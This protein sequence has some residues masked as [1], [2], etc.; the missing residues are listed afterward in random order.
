MTDT[1]IKT[2]KPEPEN[3][4]TRKKLAKQYERVHNILF[5]I[6]IVFTL[7]VLMVFIFTG[8]NGGYSNQ[9]A[10]LIRSWSNNYWLQVSIYITITT[11]IYFLL[12]TPFSFYGG[13]LLEHKYQLSNESF[14]MWIKDR[15]KSY[16]LN[17]IFMLLLGLV[18]YVFLVYA[19]HSWWLW[20]GSMWFLFGIILSNIF[21][22]IIIPLFYKLKP[23]ENEDLKNKLIFLSE[24]VKAKISGVYEIILS[25]KTK[26]ANAALTGLGNTKRI[27]L[28]DTLLD[29][30]SNEEIEV[31]LAHEL[32]HFYYKH[33]WKLIFFGAFITF[34]GLYLISL[35][36][37]DVVM[38]LGYNG[39]ADIA[40]F[41]VF[42]LCMFLFSIFTSPLNSTYSRYLEN[43]ADLFAL[44]QTNLPKDFITAMTKL[45]DQ[46]LADDQPNPII[47]F[48]LHDHPSIS[49][50]IKLAERFMNTHKAS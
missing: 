1:T 5:L 41:P 40:G 38:N 48:L 27:I 16:I 39:I 24:K 29:N 4:E 23:L 32:G 37:N 45:A 8:G 15:F 17:V 18:L 49:R 42:L 13:Y 3:P 12:L 47:E 22:I 30:F 11:T 7:M 6:D 14:W 26:K 50:R 34:A 35:I 33:I 21:P 9:L 25:T 2:A 36:F 10:G 31:V 20:V 28:G 19:K 46:N 43:Q 44:K